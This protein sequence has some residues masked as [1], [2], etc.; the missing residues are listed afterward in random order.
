MD[1]PPEAATLPG[2]PLALET[3]IRL[4]PAAMIVPVAHF[5]VM[6]LVRRRSGWPTPPSILVWQAMGV[7]MGMWVSWYEQRQREATVSLHA[8]DLAARQAA[9]RLA[10]QNDVAMGA[11]TVVDE[12]ARVEYLLAA[13][14]PASDTTTPSPGTARALAEW[15]SSLAAAT[16]EHS[17]YLATVLARYQRASY[18]VAL[19]DDLLLDAAHGQPG[20]RRSSTGGLCRRIATARLWLGPRDRSRR[21][22]DHQHRIP[23]G[24]ARRDL[25]ATGHVG[26][27]GDCGNRRAVHLAPDDSPASRRLS[28]NRSDWAEALI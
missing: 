11:D 6:T 17:V 26:G 19:A 16:S 7:G 3:G 23:S 22:I 10:G 8:R 21:W 4:G 12:V 9:A 27:G 13:A 14:V 5:A 15:K 28:R 18:G 2:V 25:P 1:G 24:R 20:V